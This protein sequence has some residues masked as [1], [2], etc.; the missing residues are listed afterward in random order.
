MNL[1]HPLHIISII[2]LLLVA[3]LA[4]GM[5]LSQ[6]QDAEDAQ[7]AEDAQDEEQAVPILEFRTYDCKWLRYKNY[8]PVGGRKLAIEGLSEFPYRYVISENRLALADLEA[9][10]T[11]AEQLAQYGVTDESAQAY[12]EERLDGACDAER[13]GGNYPDV[14]CVPGTGVM[15]DGRVSLALYHPETFEIV[16]LTT[17]IDNRGGGATDAG[18]W[19]PPTPEPAP[20]PASTEQA[21]QDPSPGCGPYAPG[22]WISAEDYD[23]SGLN[24]PIST[25]KTQ[26]PITVYV[27]EAPQGAPSYLQAHPLIKPTPRATPVEKRGSSGGGSDDDDDDDDDDNDDVDDDDPVNC[28]ANPSDPRC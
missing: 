14:F 2:L 23:A 11:L 13:L 21:P 7:N 24:L 10:D 22:Q 6:E 28:E 18:C 19:S 3:A 5:S 27:C 16:A 9:A 17:S 25:E 26:F 4:G 8:N 12:D 1:R 20:Q 15:P